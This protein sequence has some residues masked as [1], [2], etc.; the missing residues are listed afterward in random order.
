MLR[1]LEEER[2]QGKRDKV[3][4]KDLGDMWRYK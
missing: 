4:V 2:G 1:V 3:I